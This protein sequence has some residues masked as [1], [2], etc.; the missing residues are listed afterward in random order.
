MS[1]SNIRLVSGD[2][3]ISSDLSVNGIFSNNGG[4]KNFSGMTGEIRIWVSNNPPTGWLL[5]DGSSY[6]T[7]TQS[8]LFDVIGY[9]YGGSGSSFNVPDI[10][11]RSVVGSDGLNETSVSDSN[12]THSR[13]L[14]DVSGSQ[15][16]SLS[17]SQITKHKHDVDTHTHLLTN[18]G[19]SLNPHNHNTNTHEHAITL[20][21]F[22]HDHKIEHTHNGI[23]H[24]HDINHSHNYNLGQLS[25]NNPNQQI[26]ISANSGEIQGGGT[27]S[28]KFNQNISNFHTLARKVEGILQSGGSGSSTNDVTETTENQAEGITSIINSNATTYNTETLTGTIQTSTANIAQETGNIESQNTN[29]V[30]IPN[31]LVEDSGTNTPT[32]DN[33]SP[34]LVLNYIIK[35]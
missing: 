6:D 16:A 21:S 1:V 32:H 9:L 8:N 17:I 28:S 7:T 5:C 15:L 24:N 33:D 20:S 2:L 4:N 30:S 22:N 29:E 14:A 26:I 34:F 19:H 13:T 25:I 11:H 31:N 12:R 18:H 3:T 35:S 23:D 10:R 27:E